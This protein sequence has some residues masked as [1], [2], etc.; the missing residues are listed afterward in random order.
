MHLAAPLDVGTIAE[1]FTLLGL[2]PD[3]AR[4]Y[5]H[6]SV[7]GASKAGDVAAA[8]RLQR[9]ETYRTLEALVQRGFAEATNERPSR[10]A[11]APLERVLQDLLNREQARA[12]ALTEAQ[13]AIAPALQSLRTSPPLEAARNTFKVVQGRREALEELLRM[14]RRATREVAWA[15][16][17][18]L[19]RDLARASGA[20]DLALRRA[21]DG[22]RVEVLLGPGPD[23]A[24]GPWTVR[25]LA[26]EPPAP[27]RFCVVD[28]REVLAWLHTDPAPG[29]S[30]PSDQALWSDASDLAGTQRVLF[31]HL[32]ASAPGPRGPG[33]VPADR[34]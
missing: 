17:H 31:A 19:A 28:Q 21:A 11:A 1:R 13:Q 29:L 34:A 23:G 15:D 16:T 20:W 4:V 7:A 6:L 25:R 26:M 14:L 27:V 2:A 24:P 33:A 30:E 12:Q 3:E 10:F 9:T 5:V 18:P 8:L 22:L 32:W